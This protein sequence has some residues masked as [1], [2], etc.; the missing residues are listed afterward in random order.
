MLRQVGRAQRILVVIIGK[1]L[2]APIRVLPPCTFF[3]KLLNEVNL[4]WIFWHGVNNWLLIFQIIV[5]HGFVWP[6]FFRNWITIW[7]ADFVSVL[8]SYYL[9]TILL[10]SSHSLKWISSLQFWIE[11][12]FLVLSPSLGFEPWYLKSFNTFTC[13]LSIGNNFSFAG[14]CPTIR[15]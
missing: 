15:I 9:A 2:S 3:L 5:K 12:L 8:L 11:Y 10:Y 13:D 6:A 4:T 1:A 7:I 14:F